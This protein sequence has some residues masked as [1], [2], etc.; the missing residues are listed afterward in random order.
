LRWG[1]LV[2]S[3][4]EYIISL[5]NLLGA[6][7]EFKKGKN[8][9]QDI[10]TFDFNLEKN[11]FSLNKDLRGKTYVNEPYVPF[12]VYD[13]KRRHI[14]KACVR[15]RVV[16]Q[17]V[18]RVLYP[19][20]N[21]HF[22][23]DSY[24]C[25]NNKGTHKAVERLVEFNRKESK[26]YTRNIWVLKCDIS[27]FFD[28]I[29]HN[30]LENILVRKN[31][32]ENTKWLIKNIISSFEKSPGKGLPLGNV[33]SQL[34]SNVYLNEL[35]QYAKHILKA[36]YYI[37]YCDDF[38]IVSKNREYLQSLIP[39]ISE[40]LETKLK[41]SLHPRKVEIK[42]VSQGID[43]LGYVVFPYY[44]VLRTSTKKR[45]LKKIKSNLTNETRQSYLGIL[46]HCKGYKIAKLLK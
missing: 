10:Q 24:S 5:H 27:K 36:K 17:S 3:Y 28:S 13:P 16:H 30:I 29:D 22:I 20:Y 43:F 45:I 35:D 14:H 11:I 1:G 44:K 15:D 34:F 26:N 23:Y 42:K 4:F 25:I 38:V 7:R 9:K 21:K 31:L 39:K 33:T 32:D 19:F 41:L 6:W 8:K 40:F 12:Y 2:H 18:Y 37:R 46:S